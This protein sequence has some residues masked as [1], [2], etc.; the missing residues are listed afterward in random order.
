M[1]FA[2]HST[3]LRDG[4]VAMHLNRRHGIAMPRGWRPSHKKH[5]VARHAAG[6][7]EGDRS[8]GAATSPGNPT[9]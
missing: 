4:V 6:N 9:D 2:S 8:R 7:G 1:S 5:H 3:D